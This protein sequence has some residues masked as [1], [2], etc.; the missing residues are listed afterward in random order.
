M[1][2]K[3]QDKN[4]RDLFQLRL[5]DLI[6]PNHALA[7]L[8]NAI[9]WQYFENELA[10]RVL[11]RWRNLYIIFI[12]KTIRI[13]NMKANSK[14]SGLS[15]ISLANVEVYAKG[16]ADVMLTEVFY[17]GQSNYGL[18]VVI[19]CGLPCNMTRRLGSILSCL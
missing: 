9:D 2:W 12:R 8:A 4:H 7:L 16:E 10:R 6:N 5:E 18:P 17:D 19:E 11:R 1:L 3:L 14:G 13:N 15:D